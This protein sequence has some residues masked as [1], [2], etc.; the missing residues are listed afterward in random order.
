MSDDSVAD[1]AHSAGLD[2]HEL[3]AGGASGYRVTYDGA[4]VGAVR[5]FRMGAGQF[6]SGWAAE[7]VAG[8][9]STGFPT[10]EAAADW[11]VERARG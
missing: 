9:R 10:R 4:D 7:D 8:E 5:P 2:F 6:G 3:D 1:P 11:L